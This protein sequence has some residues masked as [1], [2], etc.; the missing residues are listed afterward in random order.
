MRRSAKQLLKSTLKDSPRH[1]DLPHELLH[2]QSLT[3]LI[4]DDSNGG[5]NVGIVDGQHIGRMSRLNTK[6]WNQSSVAT[7]H[8]PSH[9]LIQ[10]RRGFVAGF[11]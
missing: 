11:P 7:D 2:G 8:F 4:A 6:G 3:R 1:R 5:N 9:Q 10:H